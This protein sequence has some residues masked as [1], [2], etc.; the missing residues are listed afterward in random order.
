MGR[1]QPGNLVIAALAL[2]N[3]ALWLAFVPLPDDVASLYAFQY[4]AEICSSTAVILIALA[5]VLSA[6]PR[7]LERYF[8]GLDKMYQ[9]HKQLA[10]L[11]FLL[12]A[13]HFVTIPDSGLLNVGKPLGMLAL[14]GLVVLALLTVAPR[15]P[16]ISRL[17]HLPYHR[18]RITHKLLGLFFVVGIAHYLHVGTLST[19]TLPGRY[20]MLFAFV[21]IAAYA[22][23]Q[24]LAPFL[25]PYRPHVVEQVNR[26]N[27]TTVEVSLKPTGK[28]VDFQAGQFVFVRVTGDRH[29]RE[30]HPFTVSSSPGEELVRLTIKASGD[31]TRYLVRNLKPGTAAA[32]YGGFGMFDYKAA[33][34]HQLWIAGGIGVT[35]FLS[36]IR[37]LE[38]RPGVDVDF[39]WGVHS[40]EDALFLHE[41][42][43][44]AAKHDNFRVFVRYTVQDGSLSADQ[45]TEMASGNLAQ[46]HVYMCGP[47]GM[48]EAF[49]ARFRRLG[50]PA[51]QIHYEEFNF[52]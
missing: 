27:G 32:V 36:W 3:V 44:V 24:L 33:G 19:G 22:T 6:R 23:K 39:F 13:V 38:G 26:L 17:L 28:K 10:V 43:A 21:G 51:A 9:T 52:R 18:W 37:D 48:M 47:I 4:A 12:L 7:F 35:P 34:G 49:A 8:G 50:V 42:Q 40:I 25:E 29:L 31:W 5:L 15:L 20:M 46:K 1:R 30:A 16:L 11:A 41:F 2:L 14:V 45:I